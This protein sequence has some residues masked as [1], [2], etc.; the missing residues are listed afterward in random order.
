[1]NA[2]EF[3]KAMTPV[4]G[5]RYEY[6]SIEEVKSMSNEDRAESFKYML[7]RLRVSGG[8]SKEFVSLIFNLDRHLASQ[9]VSEQFLRSTGSWPAL[10]QLYFELACINKNWKGYLDLSSDYSSWPKEA[11]NQYWYLLPSSEITEQKF[12]ELEGI[13]RAEPDRLP[14]VQGIQALLRAKGLEF[15]SKDYKKEYQRLS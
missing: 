2:I 13:V 7:D 10:I 1:M 11:R 3:K 4:E 6:P 12:V 5:V 9:H 8:A 15:G 14:K